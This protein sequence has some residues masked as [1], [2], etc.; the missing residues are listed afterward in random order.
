MKWGGV[1]IN[2][3]INTLQ[4]VWQAF[5]DCCSA[6]MPCRRRAIRKGQERAGKG[7]AFGLDRLVGPEWVDGRVDGA[8]Q[9]ESNLLCT[10]RIA[11]ETR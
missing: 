9:A 4:L 6:E 7:R 3:H 5:E 2:V 10:G 8:L 1:E 11:L